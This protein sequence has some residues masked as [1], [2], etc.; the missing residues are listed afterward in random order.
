[1]II[2]QIVLSENAFYE[3]LAALMALIMGL[4]LFIYTNHT[5][6]T[7]AQFDSHQTEDKAHMKEVLSLR[8]RMIKAETRLEMVQQESIDIKSLLKDNYE[9]LD[10]KLERILANINKK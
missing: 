8:E 6:S 4:S 5:Q 1:M 2:L 7:K 10:H 3:I 9:K